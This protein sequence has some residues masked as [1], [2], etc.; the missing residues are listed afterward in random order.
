MSDFRQAARYTDPKNPKPHQDAAWDFAWKC[1]TADEQREFLE[2][3]RAAVPSKVE[4]T[5]NSWP[6]VL[7]AAR[8]AGARYPELV[9]AQWA[10]ESSWGKKTS[11]KNNYFGLK[12][13]GSKR[14]TQE[15]LAGKWVTIT[16]GFIDFPSLRACIEYLVSRWYK[17]YG[18][19]KGVNNAP[20]RNAAARQLES[21]GYATDPGYA[22]KLIGLMGQHAPFAKGV[23]TLQEP[24]KLTPASPFS[25]RLT[26]HIR[27][28][29]FALDR[30]ERRFRHQHQVDTAAELAAFLE[31]CRA[32]FGGMYLEITSGYR[33]AAV[34]RAVGGASGSEHLFD[35][36]GVGAVDFLIRGVDIRK[37]QDWCDR[38]WPYSLGLG[39]AKGFVHLGI[40]RGRPKVRWPY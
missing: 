39:A 20:D 11:G 17:D 3:F 38:N 13:T 29:E 34:N 9:A 14:E 7:A 6:G 31:R 32:T 33:P 35:A 5:P 8:D 26:P 37:V 1:L 18:R 16:D 22:E 27:L 30:E 23:P 25:A 40:R 36:P 19:Y 12:G 4:P 15:F 10:L 2:L 28:G 24:A 21:E